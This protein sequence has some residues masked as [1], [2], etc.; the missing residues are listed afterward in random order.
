M[1]TPESGVKRYFGGDSTMGVFVSLYLIL[2]AFFVILTA[3][4]EFEESRSGKAIDSVDQSFRGA[5]GRPGAV[6]PILRPQ[7]VA[8]S[9]QEDRMLQ[10]IAGLFGARFDLQGEY[11][12]AGGNVFRIRLPVDMFFAP[13]ALTVR[14]DLHPFFDRLVEVITDMPD[15]SRQ[16]VVFLFGRGDG[17]STE[18]STTRDELAVRRAAQ[19]SLLLKDKGMMGG[20]YAAG[21]TDVPRTEI[22][23]VFRNA[24]KMR[25]SSASQNGVPQ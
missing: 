10:R 3:R 13:G 9:P 15:H 17:L 8:T 6:S 2:L 19:L 20:T 16:E 1:E 22:L 21:F 14:S 18:A 7:P 25:D 24:P 12:K 5:K 23:A 11:L 4:S